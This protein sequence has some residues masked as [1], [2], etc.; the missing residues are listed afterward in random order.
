[1]IKK[2]DKKAR[3]RSFGLAIQAIN[4]LDKSFTDDMFKGLNREERIRLFNIFKAL[5]NIKYEMIGRKYVIKEKD[6]N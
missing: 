2:I 6:E 5:Q 1:M 4:A 3:L